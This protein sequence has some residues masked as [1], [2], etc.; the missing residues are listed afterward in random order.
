MRVPYHLDESLPD[1]HVPPSAGSV[2][3]VNVELPDADVWS[4]LAALYE[5]VAGAV[6]AEPSMPVVVSGDC[7]VSMGIACGL[8]RAGREPSIVWI[9]AHGDVQTLETT[10]SGYLGGMALRLL[11][12]YR[13]ELI[14][15]R[16][17]FR[18]VPEERVLLVDARDLDPPEV[19]YLAAAAVRRSS[20][21]DL[22][23]ETLPDGPLLVNVDL[24]VVDSAL[25]PGLR[26]PAP[27]GP[28]VPTVLRAARAVLDSGRVAAINI[29]CTWHPDVNGTRG[30]HEQVV[31]SLLADAVRRDR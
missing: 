23:A 24:D 12:G 14:A 20:V 15:E 27:D 22:S 26:Y 31:S 2:T 29:A 4:R 19:E 9:D 3:D 10:T 6:E 11:V 18:A 7:T 25:L 17:G 28:D 13:P 16:L 1:L 5:A 21:I 30:V 8:Q